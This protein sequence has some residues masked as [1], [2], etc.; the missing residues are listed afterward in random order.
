MRAGYIGEVV[1]LCENAVGY[2]CLLCLLFDCVA[3]CECVCS[4]VC[5]LA[6]LCVFLSD[7]VFVRVF[8]CVCVVACLCLCALSACEV[9]SVGV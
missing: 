2:A 5:L 7:C 6:R 8:A 1:C 3:V 9:C 4:F